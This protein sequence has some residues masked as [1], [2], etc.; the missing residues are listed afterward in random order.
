MNARR[1]GFVFVAAVAWMAI[2]ACSDC[3]AQSQSATPLKERV[4]TLEREYEAGP[5]GTYDITAAPVGSVQIAAWKDPKLRIEAR[6]ELHAPT[7][8]DLDTLASICG[9]IVD[10]SMLGADITTSGPHDSK[11]MKGVK[12]FPKNLRSLPWRIDYVIWVPRYSSIKLNVFNGETYIEGVEGI[13][14]VTSQHGPIRIA[15]LGG[16][17]DVAT[18]EGDIDVTVPTRSWRGS[19]L[20][21]SVAKGNVTMHTSS[22]FSAELSVQAFG[23]AKIV[24]DTDKDLG[25]SWRGRIG[26]GGAQITLVSIAGAILVDQTV[27]TQNAVP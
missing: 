18:A 9:F 19:G 7:D 12:N 2:A 6:L 11:L 25:Q 21:A 3:K 15:N 1:F 16:A 26:R 24:G 8:K 13:I 22:D 14:T 27:A 20:S 10:P 23:G 5:G 17:V 4:L